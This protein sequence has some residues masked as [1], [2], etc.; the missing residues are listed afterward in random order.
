MRLSWG[1]LCR[2]G[3]GGLER[4]ALL[5]PGRPCRLRS[6][7]PGIVARPLREDAF[8]MSI[9]TAQAPASSLPPN[10]ALRHPRGWWRSFN[11]AFGADVALTGEVISEY[12]E[13]SA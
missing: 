13:R 7:L 4:P 5:E 3:A 8:V 1:T 9:A 2:S 11:L 12:D 10:A 6:S